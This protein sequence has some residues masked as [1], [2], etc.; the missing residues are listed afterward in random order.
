M[1]T[2][3]YGSLVCFKNFSSAEPASLHQTPLPPM[4]TGLSAFRNRS[5]AF[6]TSSHDRE[7]PRAAGTASGDSV[8]PVNTLT[9][10]E[11]CAAP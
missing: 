10:I 6:A 9:G 4:T 7:I 11:R 3:K 1:V 8:F 2:S 5:I